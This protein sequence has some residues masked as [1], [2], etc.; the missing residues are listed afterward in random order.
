MCRAV[1][2]SEG[3]NMLCPFAGGK[4][5]R[6]VGWSLGQAWAVWAGRRGQAKVSDCYLGSGCYPS[7]PRFGR[8]VDKLENGRR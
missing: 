3:V 2:E 4:Q 5:L 6:G 1:G 7:L 8:S